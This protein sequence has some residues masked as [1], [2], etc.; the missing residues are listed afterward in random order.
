MWL[1]EVKADSTAMDEVKAQVARFRELKHALDAAEVAYK[2]AQMMYD[3][4]CQQILSQT[5]RQNG[6]EALKCDDGT[7]LTV[8]QQTKCSIK[9]DKASKDN[10]AAWLRE[11]GADNM[12]KSQ[13]IV[14]PSAKAQLDRLGIAY[15]EDVSMNTNS[16]KAYILGEMRMGN[17]TSEDLPSGLSWYQFDTISVKD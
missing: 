2:S 9:K 15:D 16:V 12:I 7:L 10:V 8:E 11:Q 3:N 1:D 14:M 5:L 17:L 6:L 4:F 13:L